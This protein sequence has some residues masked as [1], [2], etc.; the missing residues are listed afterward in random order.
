MWGGRCA[1]PSTPCAAPC[2]HAAFVPAAGSSCSD[3]AALGSGSFWVALTDMSH[4]NTGVVLRL[5]GST[6]WMPWA[7]PSP[8]EG[9]NALFHQVLN[10]NTPMCVK[11][12]PWFG[13]LNAWNV[14]NVPQQHTGSR[15]LSCGGLWA[16]VLTFTNGWESIH[17]HRTAVTGI[18]AL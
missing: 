9:Q 1:T 17:S 11:I 16:A 4:T 8:T 14:L 2:C 5:M 12:A 3:I 6:G 7:V 18:E 15:G 10:Y 13:V